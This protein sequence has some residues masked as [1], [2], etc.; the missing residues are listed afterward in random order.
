M[1]RIASLFACALTCVSLSIFAQ[2][3]S[4][5]IVTNSEVAVPGND[6]SGSNEGDIAPQHVGEADCGC[7]AGKPKN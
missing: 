1:R 4:E 7:G 5:D 3:P 2:E 6:N